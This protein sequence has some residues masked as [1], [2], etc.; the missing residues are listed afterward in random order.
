[1]TDGLARPQSVAA[2]GGNSD[3]ARATLR[4][5]VANGT[6]R[7]VLAVRDPARAAAADELPGAEVHAV[8]FDADEPETHTAA[9]AEAAAHLGDVDLAI[10]AFGVLGDQRRAER[11]PAAAAALARTN[12][13][14]G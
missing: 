14:G 3:I 12:L 6:R 7:V 8:A 11:D 9:V 4:R 2:F 5:L 10:V 13:V 1:M